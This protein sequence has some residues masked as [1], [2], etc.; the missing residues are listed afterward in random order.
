VEVSLN[1]D[2]DVLFSDPAPLDALLQRFGRVNRIRRQ[3]QPAPL[4]LYS[5][6]TGAEQR[7]SPYDVALVEASVAWLQAHDKSLID[8]SSTHLALNEIYA[9]SRTWQTRFDQ[10]LAQFDRG[11]L[12]TW[13]PFEASDR[14][15]LWELERSFNECAVLPISLEGEYRTLQSRQPLLANDLLVSMSWQQF[16]MLERL[17]VAWRGQGDDQGIYFVDLPYSTASGLQLTLE[18]EEV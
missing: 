16:A 9:H 4:H 17:E 10:S 6:P 8:E 18:D 15:L 5:E 13:E 14:A 2:F 1:L 3:K 7:F 12:Q 11:V